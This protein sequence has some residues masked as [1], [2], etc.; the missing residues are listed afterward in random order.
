M[1]SLSRY[2]LV[3]K[4][5]INS[6]YWISVKLYYS[7]HPLKFPLHTRAFTIYFNS[8]IEIQLTRIFLKLCDISQ[9]FERSSLRIIFRLVNFTLAKSLQK[10]F[11]LQQFCWNKIYYSNWNIYYWNLKNSLSHRLEQEKVSEPR[12]KDTDGRYKLNLLLGMQTIFSFRNER[13]RRRK[14]DILRYLLWFI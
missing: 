2:L 9:L 14:D 7:F 11:S 8:K 10:Y 1:L 3:F 6:L 12:M 13:T 5:Y 4:I